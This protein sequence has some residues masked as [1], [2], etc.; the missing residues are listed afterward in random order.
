MIK[1]LKLIPTLAKVTLHPDILTILFEN[2]REVSRIFQDVIGLF[3]ISHMAVN[4]INPALEA[5]IFSL[6]PNIEYNLISQNLWKDDNS[7]KLPLE[8]NKIV[9]WNYGGNN[10]DNRA[11]ERIK[12]KNN[13]FSKGLT[14]GRSLKNFN[15][16]YSFAIRNKSTQLSNDYYT[17]NKDKLID[18]GDYCLKYFQALYSSYYPSLVLPII[19]ELKFTPGSFNKHHL[20]LI[21]NNLNV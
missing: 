9:W 18:L 16:F 8:E 21:V 6:T 11:L 10:I 1:S 20:K 3:E 4:I 17:A 5:I 14:L 12:L 7:F 13:N 15:L 2:R 19:D